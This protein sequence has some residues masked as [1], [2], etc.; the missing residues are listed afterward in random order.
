MDARR[1]PRRIF[2]NHSEDQLPN[3][4]GDPS[5]P[6]LLTN[7]RDKSPIQTEP[8]PV[9]TDNSFGRDDDESLFPSRPEPTDG[10][11][12]EPVDQRQPW[13]RMPTFQDGE[14]LTKREILKDKISTTKKEA[15]EGSETERG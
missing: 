3:F 5:S 1:T 10:D 11:P 12:E 4:S 15:N 13:P 7:S 9:P 14:L 8:R 6:D 2:G